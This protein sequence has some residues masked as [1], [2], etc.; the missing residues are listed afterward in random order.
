MD[1][2][3]AGLISALINIIGV[4]MLLAGYQAVGLL[5]Y[6]AS[7][8]GLISSLVMYKPRPRAIEERGLTPEEL[9]RRKPRFP[10]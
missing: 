10:E 3:S 4:A 6:V 7:M 9:R 8:A 5:V 1:L 2:K